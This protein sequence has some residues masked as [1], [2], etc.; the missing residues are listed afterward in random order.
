MTLVLKVDAYNNG[1]GGVY[2]DYATR[3]EVWQTFTLKF[4]D[5]FD[6]FQSGYSGDV[7]GVGYG[8]TWPVTV[9]SGGS[10]IFD[11]QAYSN[12]TP[13]TDIDDW[14]SDYVPA[15]YS[16]AFDNNVP[17][18]VADHWFTCEVHY[19][20]ATNCDIYID[21]TLVFTSSI[22]DTRQT[23]RAYMGQVFGGCISYYKDMQIGS[24]RGASDIFSGDFSGGDVSAFTGSWG[25]IAV[26]TDP[27]TGPGPPANDNFVN[28]GDI[29]SNPYTT[30]NGTTIAATNEAPDALEAALGHSAGHQNVWWKFTAG[31]DGFLSMEVVGS[32]TTPIDPAHVSIGVFT[33]A[34]LAT[35]VSHGA[36]ASPI[37]N[38]VAL[39]EGQ[40]YYI[41]VDST[42]P[43]DFTIN[44]S[45]QFPRLHVTLRMDDSEG[46]GDGVDPE[47]SF[48][49]YNFPTTDSTYCRGSLR[50]EDLEFGL[51]FM[52]GAGNV[53]NVRNLKIG[54]TDWG[55]F[56]I[57]NADFSTD[58][59]ASPIDPG[60]DPGVGPVIVTGV[61]PF[62]S[63]RIYSNGTSTRGLR[64]FTSG[65]ILTFQNDIYNS[66]PSYTTLALDLGG[67]HPEI[68]LEWEFKLNNVWTT[69]RPVGTFSELFSLYGP[70]G[71]GGKIGSCHY[72]A[73]FIR[74]DVNPPYRS[75]GAMLANGLTDF[76]GFQDAIP[77]YWP[78]PADGLSSW[79]ADTWMKVGLH[80]WV[81]FP[82]G[83][84]AYHLEGAMPGFHYV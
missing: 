47:G 43:G 41:E 7:G 53:V 62:D 33:G 60:P 72:D 31:A 9:F 28:A 78:Y 36:S 35:L 40:T 73:G 50:M 30:L 44:M 45:W 52:L 4:T 1:D 81:S 71:Y 6:S 57:L 46:T 16:G 24:T 29:I 58:W 49:P 64:I 67:S 8:P 77:A 83:A 10:G 54:T 63:A 65:G 79:R 84:G 82:E 23:D 5:T 27:P 74:D 48:G 69:P 13:F 19:H 3:D 66:G 70:G 21:G 80:Y 55:S 17:A 75:T 2:V 11:F 68:Y 39:V 59:V 18:P 37:L 76:A 56:D 12:F 34:S 14:V 20:K 51:P 15:G 25:T 22:T 38:N 32:G 61:P 26:V 42:T